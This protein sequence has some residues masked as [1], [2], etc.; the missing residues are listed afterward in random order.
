MPPPSELCNVS[1]QESS[2][3]VTVPLPVFVIL[4]TLS[5]S[6]I[7]S[8]WTRASCSFEALNERL[9]FTE[10]LINENSSYHMD[11]L[12]EAGPAFKSVLQEIYLKIENI[13]TNQYYEPAGISN[14]P[15]R[16]LFRYRQ[17]RG[18]RSCHSRLCQLEHEIKAYAQVTREAR[19]VASHQPMPFQPR[20]QNY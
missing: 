8:K 5:V 4:G 17:A 11:L 3:S 1:M 6:W 10:N 14:I 18:M 19:A 12:S 7:A 9:Q 16:I 2:T 15:A 13:K 20:V